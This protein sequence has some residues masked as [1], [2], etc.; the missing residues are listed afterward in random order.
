VLIVLHEA[1]AQ[2]DGCGAQTSM[3]CEVGSVS[4]CGVTG[5]SWSAVRLERGCEAQGAQRHAVHKR[6][7]STDVHGACPLCGGHP[8][9]TLAV[10]GADCS[11]GHCVLSLKVPCR[12]SLHAGAAH[13]LRRAVLAGT[14]CVGQPHLRAAFRGSQCSCSTRCP[15][16][17]A[18]EVGAAHTSALKLGEG[19]A[20]QCSAVWQCRP[21]QAPLRPPEVCRMG[22]QHM[23][24]G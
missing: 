24:D 16:P 19:H 22:H 6:R 17:R 23:P 10:L 1:E 3:C 2:E 20:R 14:G 12:L 5:G 15:Q 9:F 21:R 18:H 7:H 4:T 13:R 8:P 11:W